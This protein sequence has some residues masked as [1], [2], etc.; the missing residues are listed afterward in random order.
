MSAAVRE[1]ETLEAS[2]ATMFDVLAWEME[3][4]AARC[5]SLDAIIGQ[6]L[7]NMPDAHQSE[8]VESAHTVDLLSQQLTSLSAFARRMSGTVAEDVSASV[9]HALRD[10]TLGALADRMSVAFGGKERGINERD[11]AGDLDLF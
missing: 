1:N 2:V 8:Y 10:I 6:M 11:E 9:D 5:L 7:R 4:A 3:L